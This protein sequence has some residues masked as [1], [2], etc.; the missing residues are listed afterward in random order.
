[1]KELFIVIL[2]YLLPHTIDGSGVVHEEIIKWWN[3]M[4]EQK[5]IKCKLNPCYSKSKSFHRFGK[6]IIGTYCKVVF[7]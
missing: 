3:K 7:I 6:N 1:M 2:I 5:P 4:S